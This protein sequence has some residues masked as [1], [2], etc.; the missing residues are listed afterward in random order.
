MR[1]LTKKEKQKNAAARKVKRYVKAVEDFI[2]SKN[3]GELPIE[4]EASLDMLSTYYALYLRMCDEIDRLTSLMVAENGRVEMH[5]L[6]KSRDSV[7]MRL[8]SLLKSMGVTFQQQVKMKII[9][10]TK[11]DANPLEEW[12]DGEKEVR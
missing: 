10:V 7:V 1:E 8:D 9:D 3:G 5:P 2:R 11:P 12:L 6:L 4:L